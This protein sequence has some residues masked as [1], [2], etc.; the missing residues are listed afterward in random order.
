[1]K[2]LLISLVFVS[3][4][5]F[6]EFAAD[7]SGIAD[8]GGPGST[9]VSSAGTGSVNTDNTHAGAEGTMLMIDSAT[10]KQYEIKPVVPCKT[11]YSDC[12]Y[13][14]VAQ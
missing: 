12:D 9:E 7:G 6:A 13:Q 5:A 1:M 3:S 8:N 11:G 2:A 10:G 14:N 4:T